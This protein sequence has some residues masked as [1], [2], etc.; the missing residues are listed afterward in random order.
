MENTLIKWMHKIISSQP[1]FHVMLNNYSGF[2]S[3]K[4]VFARVQDHQPFKQLASSLQVINDYI[5]DNG[6]PSVRTINHPHMTIARSLQP[7]VYEKAMMD[8]SRK[9]FNASFMVNRLVLLKRQN[10]YDKCKQVNIFKL[11]P[12]ISLN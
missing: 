1:G 4:T 8:Y 7:N 10:Q 6:L 5:K 12:A 9:T 2:P 3:S 11:A